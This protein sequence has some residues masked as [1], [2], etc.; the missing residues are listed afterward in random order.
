VVTTAHHVASYVAIHQESDPRRS[1]MSGDV[2]AGPDSPRRYEVRLK[3]RLR[4]R[5]AAWFD[6]LSLVNEEGGT[7]V[8]QGEVVDEAA[9]HGLLRKVRDSGLPLLSVT[10]IEPD[11]PGAHPTRPPEHHERTQS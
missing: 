1:T 4:P 5:W 7:T 3:G 6:G 10:R 11:E 2:A 9:L 8:L